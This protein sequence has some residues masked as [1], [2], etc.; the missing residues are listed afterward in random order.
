[1][2]EGGYLFLITGRFNQKEPEA[3][4]E[5]I[6]TELLK[7]DLGI[8]KLTL[9]SFCRRL[10]SSLLNNEYLKKHTLDISLMK[11]IPVI[12]TDLD[13]SKSSCKEQILTLKQITKKPTSRNRQNQVPRIL[14]LPHAK[15]SLVSENSNLTRLLGKGSYYHCLVEKSFSI[16]E[17]RI[18]TSIS[19][20]KKANKELL[21]HLFSRKGR[22]LF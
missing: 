17:K 11:D 22:W 15:S 18:Y 4:L 8:T 19:Y 20:Y 2:T 13:L 21:T 10:N 9:L 12:V 3:K 6:K 16:N 14:D 1:M 5:N 7:L